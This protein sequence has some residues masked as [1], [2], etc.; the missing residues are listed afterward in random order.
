MPRGL[1]A[2]QCYHFASSHDDV[3]FCRNTKSWLVVIGGQW[4]PTKAMTPPVVMPFED[5]RK[6]SWSLDENLKPLSNT[7]QYGGAAVVLHQYLFMTG[8]AHTYPAS[9][10]DSLN[11]AHSSSS[12]KNTVSN[13]AWRFNSVTLKCEQMTNMIVARKYHVAF[14]YKET[15][16]VAG[17]KND[18]KKSL[19]STEIY[20]IK[21][22]SWELGPY[23]PNSLMLL[24]GCSYKEQA[25]ISGGLMVKKH[26]EVSSKKFYKYDL[27]LNEW[28]QKAPMSSERC[29]HVMCSTSAGIYVVGGAQIY[30]PSSER[31]STT[32]NHITKPEFY[33]T[34]K[35]Q[36]TVLRLDKL[37]LRVC[38]PSVVVQAE[39]IYVLGG[40]VYEDP[41]SYPNNR[42]VN[43]IKCLNTQT[44]TMSKVSARLPFQIMDA[45]MAVMPLPSNKEEEYSP[46]RHDGYDD[47][48]SIDDNDD[49]ERSNTAYTDTGR[50]AT[51]SYRSPHSSPET[52]SDSFSED[53][54]HGSDVDVE[55]IDD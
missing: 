43:T 3:L 23:M 47:Y 21:N 48:L 10:N 45:I 19:S 51:D 29:E 14:L 24:A 9:S 31:A 27:T 20:T 25:Y 52:N 36:W 6:E 13:A 7:Y 17:G 54:W 15:I 1:D 34:A 41:D 44:N 40:L 4:N 18:S 35:D 12:G 11:E 2:D 28:I 16:L 30:R 50:S 8:G 32:I 46:D 22:N 26:K 33:D 55:S 39:K 38:K 53:T 5:P 42:M 37:D 49:D